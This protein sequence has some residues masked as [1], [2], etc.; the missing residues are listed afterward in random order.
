M[1]SKAASQAG[2]LHA[3]ILVINAYALKLT[4]KMKTAL[5]RIAGNYPDVLRNNMLVTYTNTSAATG[6]NFN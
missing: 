3:I 2:E 5:Q 4:I 1:I 6:L